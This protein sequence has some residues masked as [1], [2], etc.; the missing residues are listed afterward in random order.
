MAKPLTELA[1][2]P[3]STIGDPE[4]IRTPDLH[5][6]RVLHVRKARS[7]TAWQRLSC[8]PFLQQSGEVGRVLEG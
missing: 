2:G 8:W 5:R 7:E 4:G 6:D 1:S 3:Q